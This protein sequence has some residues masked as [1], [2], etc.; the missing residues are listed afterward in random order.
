VIV[1]TRSGQVVA[2]YRY[3]QEPLFAAGA[4]TGVTAILEKSPGVYLV[5]ERSFHPQLGNKVRLFEYRPLQNKKRLLA[6]I[7]Q[8][9]RPDNLEGMAW[10]P[11]GTLWLV[12]DDNFNAA[13]VTQFIALEVR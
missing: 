9:V 7:G 1:Q 6:D 8:F 10:A 3:Q 5:L 12:S 13:Q 2:Q 11:D 4:S